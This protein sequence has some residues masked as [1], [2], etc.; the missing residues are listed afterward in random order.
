MARIRLRTVVAVVTYV[1]V[2]VGLFVRAE[3]EEPAP[4]PVALAEGR[5]PPAASPDSVSSEPPPPGGGPV[6]PRVQTSS[7]PHAAPVPPNSI[8]TDDP[9]R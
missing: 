9:P 5:A 4:P 8:G 3:P 2:A 6:Q 1:F 7:T